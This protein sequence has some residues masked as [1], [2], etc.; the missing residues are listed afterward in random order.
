MDYLVWVLIGYFSG[1]IPIGYWIGRLKGIDLTQIGS[2]STGAT[3]VLRN[4]G[5]IEALITLI[6]DALKGF[7]PVF[8]AMKFQ[9]N[10]LIVLLVSMTCI[11]GHSK[12]I[13]LRF[14]GGKSSATG[15]GILVAFSWQAAVIVFSIWLIIVFTSRY[16][17]LGSIISI[18]LTPVFLY[19]FHR[20][21]PY[22]LFGVFAAVYIVLFRHRE[23]IQRLLNGTEPKI[24]M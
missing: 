8:F 5:K 12:S 2:G 4:I 21:M 14:K 13:F 17:S 9:E 1:S 22:V 20:P 3:N 19:L 7:L 18:P 11:I 16:S 6:C 15:L 24:G 10:N 23:N